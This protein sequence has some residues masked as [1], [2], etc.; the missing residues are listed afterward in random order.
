VRRD[1]RCGPRRPPGLAAREPYRRTVRPGADGLRLRHAARL[2][3]ATGRLSPTAGSAALVSSLV[4]L[5]DGIAALRTAQQR[6]AQASA[7]RQA[8]DAIRPLGRPTGGLEPGTGLAPAAPRVPAP[9]A[10]RT[11]RPT[12]SR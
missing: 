7:A 5:A 4:V 3:A 6:A 10:T 1:V 8:A 9:A 2:I 12:R 11:T